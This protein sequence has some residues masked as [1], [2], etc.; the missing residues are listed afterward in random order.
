MTSSTNSGAGNGQPG[1]PNGTQLVESP[2]GASAAV[3]LDHQARHAVALGAGVAQSQARELAET[4]ARYLMAA[5]FPRD[6]R[7]A[8]D[9]ILN[10]FARPKLAEKAQYQFARG[11]QDVAG[12]SIRAAEAIAQQWENM[13][14]GWREVAR[15]ID[16]TGCGYSE[17]EAFCIDLQ[18]R[19]TQRRTF[20]VRHWR[21]TKGGGY[22]LKDERDIYELCANQAMRRVRAC[23]LASLPGDVVEAAMEQAETT[24][25]AN[26]DTSPAAMG[27]LVEAF[28]GFGVSREQIEKRIQ[29]R[30]DSISAAQVL[31]LRRIYASLRDDMSNAGDWFEPGAGSGAATASGAGGEAA[32]DAPAGIAA[33]KAAAAARSTRA[34]SAGVPP[35]ATGTAVAQAN[36]ETGEVPPPAAAGA[37]SG[38]G[39]ETTSEGFT[40]ALLQQRIAGCSDLAVLD[41]LADDVRSLPEGAQRNSLMAAVIERARAIGP[42]SRDA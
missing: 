27:K 20:V 31:M 38:S 19:N 14:T 17:V 26:A 40:P 35:A 39:S 10:A 18:S 21:D 32:G 41:M 24:L 11:G 9:R 1:R 36:P 12:P 23:I 25:K 13:D 42:T 22:K 6:E 8:M 33:V 29:R 37:A 5:R 2:F 4:Q 34:R 16:A 28:A 30:L 7:A 3:G 15:G